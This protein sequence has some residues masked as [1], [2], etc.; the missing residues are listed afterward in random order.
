[1]AHDRV[2]A[3]AAG[4]GGAMLQGGV[5]RYDALR[6]AR[7]GAFGVFFIGPVMHKWF[8][9]L[10]KVLLLLL[11]LCLLLPSSPSVHP[12]GGGGLPLCRF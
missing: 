5:W 8:A 2:A 11:L 7:Q 9:I 10:D 6:T 3:A 4:G 1:M 12:L